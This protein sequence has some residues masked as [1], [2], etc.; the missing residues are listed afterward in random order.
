M[1]LLH[2]ST[3]DKIDIATVDETH[4]MIS[5]ENGRTLDISVSNDS[6]Y[7][8]VD[9]LEEGFTKFVRSSGVKDAKIENPFIFMNKDI[10]FPFFMVSDVLGVGSHLTDPKDCT[11]TT[12]IPPWI[13]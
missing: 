8:D 4:L 2:R 11:G 12:I 7:T 10:N 6:N 3:V 1:V 13:S 5:T 9:S